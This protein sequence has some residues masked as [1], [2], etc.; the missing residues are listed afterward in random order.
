MHI[1]KSFMLP[2]VRNSRQMYSCILPLNVGKFLFCLLILIINRRIIKLELSTWHALVTWSLPLIFLTLASHRF[3]GLMNKRNVEEFK[4]MAFVKCSEVLRI[5]RHFSL[6]GISPH[7]FQYWVVSYG[8]LPI[9]DDLAFLGGKLVRIAV[10][11][12]IAKRLEKK[13]LLVDVSQLV[14]LTT[15]STV[16]VQVSRR[17]SW[18]ACVVCAESTESVVAYLRPFQRWITARTRASRTTDTCR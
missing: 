13:L 4:N 9:E 2:L 12:T 10:G 1:L 14:A 7:H 18:S 5:K 15:I 8:L 17:F 11:V 3:I 6:V 16:H